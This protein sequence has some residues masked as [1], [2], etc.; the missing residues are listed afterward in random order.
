MARPCACI[1]LPHIQLTP[2]LEKWIWR[3]LHLH[4]AVAC[5]R[6]RAQH[7]SPVTTRRGWYEQDFNMV[8]VRSRWDCEAD[9]S[10]EGGTNLGRC[11]LLPDL[12]GKARRLEQYPTPPP[13][14]PWPLMHCQNTNTFPR[15]FKMCYFLKGGWSNRYALLPQGL[16]T[17]NKQVQGFN[18]KPFIRVNQT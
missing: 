18:P 13:H 7:D 9:Q 14:W 15:G 2:L 16:E 11:A 10:S 5:A 3:A 6:T 12:R 1:Q 17:I 8:Y 4:S